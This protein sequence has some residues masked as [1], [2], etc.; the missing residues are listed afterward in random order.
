M[1][2]PARCPTCDRAECRASETMPPYVHSAWER[3]SKAEGRASADDRRLV[4]WH[5]DR[6]RA[7]EADCRAHAVDW[8]ARAL[9]AE[10]ALAELS[11]LVYS[12]A[13]GKETP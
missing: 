11:P 3:I 6:V 10:A 5:A 1:A 13:S 8:R 12:I 9:K 4:S 2:D 7:A